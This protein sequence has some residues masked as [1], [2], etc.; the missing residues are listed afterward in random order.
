MRAFAAPS[1]AGQYVVGRLAM[2]RKIRWEG[3]AYFTDD[4]AG[5]GGMHFTLH[6][7][8]EQAIRE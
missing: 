4:K 6:N 5:G 7:K 8:T 2:L 1:R 3:C